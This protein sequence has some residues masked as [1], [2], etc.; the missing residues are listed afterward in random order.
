MRDKNF[1]KVFGVEDKSFY[2]CSPNR[3][4]ECLE[5]KK[6]VR[7]KAEPNKTR[8]LNTLRIKAGSSTIRM[9]SREGEA[10]KFFKEMS[11]SITR[12]TQVV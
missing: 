11:S 3:N 8:K 1:K 7:R 10:E 4:G 2:L 9:P 12:T 5:S 6:G